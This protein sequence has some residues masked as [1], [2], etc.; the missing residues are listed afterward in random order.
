MTILDRI[1]PTLDRELLRRGDG[2][3]AAADRRCRDCRRTPLV[4]E[5]IYL[6]EGDRLACELCQPLRNDE[7]VGSELVHGP[8]YDQVV[9]LRGAPS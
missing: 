5:R 4:G 1:A 3:R 9:R 2:E 7:P 6:Y 8:A